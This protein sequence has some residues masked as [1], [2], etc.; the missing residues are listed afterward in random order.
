MTLDEPCYERGCVQPPAW[1]VD[2]AAGRLPFCEPHASFYLD[3]GPAIYPVE[4]IPP[5]AAAL[6]SQEA[7]E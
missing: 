3:K 1:R 4:P 7:G 5:K 6:Q 2:T